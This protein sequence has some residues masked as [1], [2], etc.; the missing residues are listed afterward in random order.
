MRKSQRWTPFEPPARPV[1]PAIFFSQNKL[2][3]QPLVKATQ[4]RFVVLD[5]APAFKVIGT[6]TDRSATYDFLLTFHSNHGPISRRFRDKWRIQ[7]K[8]AIFHP[9]YFALPLTR[10]PLELDTEYRRKGSKKLEWWAYRAEQEVWQYLQP[11]GY[12]PPTWQ[13]DWHQTTAKTAVRLCI[14][15][16]AELLFRKYNVYNTQ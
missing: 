3:G 11:C 13:T 2:T 15:H 5:I 12:N 1:L 8:I 14:L 10:F 7:S 9:V 6:D 4:L 16:S